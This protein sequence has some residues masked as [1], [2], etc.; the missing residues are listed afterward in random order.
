M[1]NAC[2]NRGWHYDSIIPL[3][4]SHENF[5]HGATV[6]HT[7]AFSGDSGAWWASVLPCIRAFVSQQIFQLL[8]KNKRA[9][10]PFEQ[11]G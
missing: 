4:L 3:G 11:H 7:V 2:I 6:H 8:L 5:N 1:N 9:R 10:R